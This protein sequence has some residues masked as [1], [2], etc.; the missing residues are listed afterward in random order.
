MPN[1]PAS[2]NRSIGWMGLKRG[3]KARPVEW[4]A[5]QAIFLVSLSAI[6]MIFLIFLFVAREALPV[7]LGKTSS[8]KST[9]VIPVAEF[10][11]LSPA[12]LME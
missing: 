2:A 9:R 10:D 6:V 12:E 3:H 4:I 7:A 5:E 11:K 8:A 1:K